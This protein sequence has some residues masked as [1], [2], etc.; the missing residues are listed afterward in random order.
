MKGARAGR[1]T[2]SINLV[3]EPFESKFIVIGPKL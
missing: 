1:G 2:V 3:L